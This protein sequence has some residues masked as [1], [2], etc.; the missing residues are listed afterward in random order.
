MLYFLEKRVYNLDRLRSP[1]LSVEETITLSY[2]DSFFGKGSNRRTN[3]IQAV[4]RAQI[5][6][7]ETAAHFKILDW[8]L[9]LPRFS[10]PF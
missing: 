6:K 2:V 7:K 9:T 10:T 3:F 1:S 4:F 5:Y 8:Q